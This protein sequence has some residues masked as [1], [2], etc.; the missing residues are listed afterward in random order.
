VAD[1]S[2]DHDDEGVVQ[3]LEVLVVSRQLSEQTNKHNKHSQTICH[4]IQ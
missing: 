3:R 1:A 2:D 4:M